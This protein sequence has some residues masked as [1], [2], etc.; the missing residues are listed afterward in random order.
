MTISGFVAFCDDIRFENNGKAIIVG[1]YSEDL[2]PGFLPQVLPLSFWVRLTGLPSG[3][4][5]LSM[6]IGTNDKVQQTASVT[7]EVQ[8]SDRP[9]NLYFVGAPIALEESGE[10]FLEL[11]GFPDG[12][13][14]RDTLTVRSPSAAHD[15]PPSV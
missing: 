8:A 3:K 9:A 13:V 10:I 5:E 14:F 2:I 4:T 1:L 6:K 7:L 11:S 15:A 12:S